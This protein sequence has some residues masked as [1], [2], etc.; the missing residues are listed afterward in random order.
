MLRWNLAR[1]CNS[2]TNNAV[3]TEANPLN[4]SLS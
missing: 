3:N 4:E 1:L 2:I